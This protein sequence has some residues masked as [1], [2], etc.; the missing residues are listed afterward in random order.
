MKRKW[1]FKSL[2]FLLIVYL[3]GCCKPELIGSVPNMLRPQQTNNWCWAATT[4][5]LA[6]HFDISVNQ[7]DL[8]NHRFGRTDCCTGD[9]PKTDSCNRP[10][11]PE[12]DY[13]GLSFKESATALSWE[14]LQRQIYC[15]KKPMGYAYGTPGVVGHVLVIKGYVTVG[16]THYLVLNDPWSPC[17]GSERLITYAEYADPAGTATHWDTFYDLAKK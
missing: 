12:L 2:G 6:Q 16:N 14:N 4:Q 5:M 8:A 17:N 10:G 15:S 13:V 3:S 11:W 7:C 9:C 1:I